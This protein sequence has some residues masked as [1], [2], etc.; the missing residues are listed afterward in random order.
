VLLGG[1]STSNYYNGKSIAYRD[2]S[3]KNKGVRYLL[4]LGVEQNNQKAFYYFNQAAHDGDP[5]AQNELA[6]M[7]GVGKGTRRDYAKA[8]TWY[9][10]AA[11]RGL[12]SAQYNLGILYLHGLGTAP[13][14]AMAK[15]WFEKSAA[16]GFMPAR[17][18]LEHVH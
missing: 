16:L 7:Y 6:F 1:C 15:R 10:K 9:Q 8:L 4:G 14:Q 5:L 11:D 13:N 12:A 18:A 3:P 17:I 2:N